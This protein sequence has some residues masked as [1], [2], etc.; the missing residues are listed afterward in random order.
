MKK[1][2]LQDMKNENRQLIIRTIIDHENLS[3]I[4]ISQ[5]SGLSPSTVS[6]LVSE[7]IKDAVLIETGESASTGGRKRT[8]LSINDDFA[9]IVI[10]D[11]KRSGA[12]MRLFDMQLNEQDRKVLSDDYLSGNEL[13]IA[14]TA[15]IFEFKSKGC[16]YSEKLAGIGLLFQ[17]DMTEGE[18]NVMYSTSLSS[19]TITL[20]DALF[21]QFH[22]PI[23]DEYSQSYTMVQPT[24]SE[25]IAAYRNSAFIHIGQRVLASITIEGKPVELRG[26]RVIDITPLVE[27]EKC[28]WLAISEPERL[29]PQLKQ[30]ALSRGLLDSYTAAGERMALAVH[31]LTNAF[32]PLCVYFSIDTIFLGGTLSKLPEFTKAIHLSLSKQLAPLPS[33]KIKTAVETTDNLADVL[34]EKIRRSVLCAN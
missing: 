4:E 27:T 10:I 32:K 29:K 3:R 2:S 1:A 14:I 18:F 13:L 33:P 26:G 24:V 17:E 34:A 20:K 5:L 28:K 23:I 6:S 8:G 11:V 19:A 15:A 25:E 31:Q 12:V 22:V 16:I 30:S 7:L 21:T 9:S